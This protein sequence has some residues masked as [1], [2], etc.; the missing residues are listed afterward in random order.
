MV[1]DT[2]NMTLTKLQDYYRNDLPES[3]LVVVPN[4]M[5]KAGDA[6]EGDGISDWVKYQMPHL[7]TTSSKP[8][9]DAARE[10]VKRLLEYARMRVKT[11]DHKPNLDEDIELVCKAVLATLVQ[12]TSNSLTNPSDMGPFNDEQ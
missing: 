12:S 5:L 11:G 6:A 2:K 10:A 7:S 1:I 3:A 9:L 4:G 8:A